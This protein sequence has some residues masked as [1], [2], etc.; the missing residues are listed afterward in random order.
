VIYCVVPQAL[1][2]E[3]L[4]RLSDY[5]SDDPNVEVMVD[6]RAQGGLPGEHSPATDRRRQRPTGSFPPIDLPAN[7]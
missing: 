7:R 6:R 1:A 4:D 3:L 5:Y 2:S